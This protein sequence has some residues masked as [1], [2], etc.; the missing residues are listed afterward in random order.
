[1]DLYV[2][3]PPVPHE[4]VEPFLAHIATRAS[5]VPL[6]YVLGETAFCGI[7]LT[8]KPGVFIP[9]PE[10][11]SLVE[12]A[13]QALHER[14][15]RADRN[16]PLRLVDAGTGS[17]GIALAL[18][19]ALPACTVVGVEVSCTALQVARQNVQRHGAASRVQLLQ[20]RWLEPIGSG[21]DG[22]LSNPPYVP[23]AQVDRLPLDVRQ[24]PRL[25]LDGGVDGMQPH[26][27]LMADA[28]RVLTP[29]GLLALECGEDQA[30]LLVRLARALAWVAEAISFDDLSGRPRGVLIFRRA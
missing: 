7:P 21:V 20:G 29:G 19:R 5:G 18:T 16:H 2:E 26:R 27:A 12:H 28:P 6:Q 13:L 9:R 4:L 25:S 23:S 22:I 14:F 17:G 30:E 8:V 3:D 15:A 24:E 11:E 1:M 10:T